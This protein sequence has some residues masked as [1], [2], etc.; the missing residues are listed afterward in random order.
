[1]N[2]QNLHSNLL[3]LFSDDITG[4]RREHTLSCLASMKNDAYRGAIDGHD[5]SVF[6]HNRH[7]ENNFYDA[8]TIVSMQPEKFGDITLQDIQ[9]LKLSSENRAQMGWAARLSES[10]FKN[11][12]ERIREEKEEAENSAWGLYKVANGPFVRVYKEPSPSIG[13]SALLTMAGFIVGKLSPECRRRDRMRE[14]IKSIFEGNGEF[15]SNNREPNLK[16]S[17]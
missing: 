12:R 8:V 15:L 17:L 5:K 9:K 11:A 13:A 2:N 10:L 4:D 14:N 1:M 16:N 3:K 6:A 7:A